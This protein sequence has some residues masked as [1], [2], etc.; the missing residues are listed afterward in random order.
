VSRYPTG[1]T[2]V[3]VFTLTPEEFDK[4]ANGDGVIV[5]YGRGEAQEQ[6]DFG[7]LD[8]SRLQRQ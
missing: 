2:H 3:L 8:K 5:Q 6:W 4:T 7:T 1:D